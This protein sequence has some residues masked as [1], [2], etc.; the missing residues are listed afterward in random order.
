MRRS[1]ILALVFCGILAADMATKWATH[2]F[3]T[4]PHGPLHVYPYGGIGVFKNFLGISLSLNYVGNT[5][6]AWGMLSNYSFALLIG[7]L[8]LVSLLVWYLLRG[9]GPT[10]RLSAITLIV[11]GA[12]GNIFDMLVYKHVIDMVKFVFWGYH[13][14]VFNIADVAICTGIGLLIVDSIHGNKRQQA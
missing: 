2:T 12:I 14:P 6:A 10:L 9:R 1:G 11:A 13:Y 3:L 4:V 8:F 5:G 7:R